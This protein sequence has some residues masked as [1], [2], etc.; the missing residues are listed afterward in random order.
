MT[1]KRNINLYRAKQNM[2]DSE[3]NNRK[4]IFSAEY[5]YNG[6]C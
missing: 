4:T 3:N 2:D 1:F 6:L 5:G